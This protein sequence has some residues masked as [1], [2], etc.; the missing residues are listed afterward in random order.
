MDHDHTTAEAALA[1]LAEAWA[2]FDAEAEI[3]C[4]TP[5]YFEYLIA[6]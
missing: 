5:E 1:I 3:S 6:A 2:Y 4:D